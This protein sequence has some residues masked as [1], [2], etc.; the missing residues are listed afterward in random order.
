M[1]Y[2]STPSCGDSQATFPLT[3]IST[4][5]GESTNPPSFYMHAGA[6]SARA[7]LSNP[8]GPSSSSIPTQ[9]PQSSPGSETSSSQPKT[10]TLFLLFRTNIHLPFPIFSKTKQQ[11]STEH[12]ASTSS[13][14]SLSLY[15]NDNRDTE[16]VLHSPKSLNHGPSSTTT[17]IWSNGQPTCKDTRAADLQNLKNGS[18]SYREKEQHR[19]SGSQ[20]DNSKL[21][22]VVVHKVL[23][24]QESDADTPSNP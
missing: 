20:A 11:T 10:K 13:T 21:S 19:T 9:I 5:T 3:H 8:Q 7:S 4:A 6:G 12:R 16:A 24:R 14:N 2:F 23:E 18:K 17:N 15:S 22:G 1:P